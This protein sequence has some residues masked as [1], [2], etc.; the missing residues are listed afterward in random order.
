MRVLFEPY[1]FAG[2]KMRSRFVSSATVNNLT[3]KENRF[4]TDHFKLYT[5]LAR[6]GVGL[7]IGGVHRRPCIAAESA[8]YRRQNLKAPLKRVEQVRRF[9]EKSLTGELSDYKRKK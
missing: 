2:I 5:D 7:I 3:N 8:A 4:T 9:V 6:G 1:E